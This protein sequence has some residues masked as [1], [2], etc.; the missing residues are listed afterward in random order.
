MTYPDDPGSRARC[1]PVHID[2]EQ[3]RVTLSVPPLSVLNNDELRDVL[4]EVLHVRCEWG[5]KGYDVAY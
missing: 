5:R 4:D 1:L 3:R 2:H